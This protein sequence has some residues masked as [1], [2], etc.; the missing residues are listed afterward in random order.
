MF[1]NW[2]YSL[3]ILALLI[4]GLT[5][6]KEVEAYSRATNIS[7]SQVS[8]GRY[9]ILGTVVD[10]TGRPACG[11]ALASGRCVFSCGPGSLR[12]EGGT[13]SLSLGQFNLT[14]LPTETNGTIVLQTFVAGNL[15]GQ[16]VLDP[17]NGCNIISEPSSVTGALEL[18]SVK[19]I[20]GW[21]YD[22][23]AI[24]VPVSVKIFINGN[25]VATVQANLN[26]F[27]IDVGWDSWD[28]Y[29]AFCDADRKPSCPNNIFFYKPLGWTWHSGDRV[30]VYAASQTGG[31]EKLIGSQLCNI[32]CS[33][34]NDITSCNL[35]C[36]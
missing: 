21:A 14:N 18:V 19:E 17:S 15:P 27:D 28:Y 23:A 3:A 11:L 5:T 36:N 1:N 25:S 12:C 34:P 13:D 16:Q 32:V 26:L 35:S 33:N 24:S 6:V 29:Y 31:G 22:T 10:S 7:C 8:P 2:F 20:S 30:D 4:I 9:Q